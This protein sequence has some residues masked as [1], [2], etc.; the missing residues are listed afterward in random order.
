MAKLKMLTLPKK[1]KQ[2]ASA[3]TMERY[4][5]KVS[6][7]KKTN[8]ARAA[9]NSKLERLKKAISGIKPS[10]VMPGSRTRSASPKRKTA[11]KR[12]AAVK[13]KAAP[14]KS[15]KRRR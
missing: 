9:E 4:L 12:K 13:K 8:S 5:E 10:D 6:D 1:P 7:I 15:A 2:S 11:T 14:K 3:T